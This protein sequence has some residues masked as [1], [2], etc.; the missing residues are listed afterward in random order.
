MGVSKCITPSEY[1]SLVRGDELSRD[2]PLLHEKVEEML[3]QKCQQRTN[4]FGRLQYWGERPI[5]NISIRTTTAYEKLPGV[6]SASGWHQ[7]KVGDE[8]GGNGEFGWFRLEFSVP[9]EY[10]GKTLTAL[11]NLGGEGCLFVNGEPYQGVDRFHSEVILAEKATAGD[12][13]EL[14]AECVSSQVWQNQRHKV[15]V[16][17]ASIAVLIPAV[18][19]YF[20]D[21]RFLLDVASSLPWGSRRRSTIIRAVNKSVDAFNHSA[22]TFEALTDSALKAREIIAPLFDNP[23]VASSIE[24]A[25]VGHSHIDTAWLWPYAET[26]RKCARTFSTVDKLMDEYEFYLFSQS[27]AQLYEFTAEN[28]PSLYERLKKRVREGRFEPIGSMW[29]EADCNL[30][31]GEALVRQI[32]LGKTYFLEEFGIET[33]ELWLPDVFGYSAAIPQILRKA[34]IEYFKTVKVNWSQFNAFPYTSFWW[35]GIDGSRVLAHVPP[36]GNYNGNMEAGQLRSHEENNRQKDRSDI[37]LYTYGHGDGGGGPD[38]NHLEVLKRAGNF[39]GVPKCTPMKVSRFFEELKKRSEDLPTWVG[40]LYLE[41]HRGTYTSQARNKRANRKSELLLRDAEISC[42]LAWMLS[43]KEYPHDKLRRAWKLL[44]K[45]QF[46]DVIPGTSVT[47]VY[48]D[49]AR[50]YEEIRAIGEEALS[51]GLA[52]IGAPAGVGE[53]II[54]FNTLSFERSDAVRVTL[55]DTESDWRV[56]TSDGTICASQRDRD[57]SSALWFLPGVVPGLGIK[58]FKLVRGVSKPVPNDIAVSETRLENS[59]CRVEL[60]D[61][62]L[63]TSV[64]DKRVG[65]EV[66]PL[67]TKANLMQIFED[68]PLAWDAWDIEFYY[69]DKG[70]DVTQVDEVTIEES[71]PVRGSI[72][73]RRRMG[74]SVITQ[75]IVLW[76]HSPRIDFETTVDWHEDSK[77]LKVAFPVNVRTDMAT[78]EIQF[79]HVKRPTHENTSWEFARFEV[80]AHKWVDLSERGYGVSLLNDCKYGHDI[81]NNVMRLTLLRS[82]K[83][84][85]PYAD[86]GQHVFTY[87]LLPHL[88]NLGE[89]TINAAYELNVPLIAWLSAA[90][91]VCQGGLIAIDSR[92]VIIEAL[93]K[94]EK[95]DALIV[96]MYESLGDTTTVYFKAD[97]LREFYAT[98]C[99]LLERDISEVKT[100]KGL[101]QLDFRPFEIK[102]LKLKP[103]R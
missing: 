81:R 14:I 60:D 90:E 50:D 70:E 86:M 28:Y 4:H 59:V 88:N 67:G 47:D 51:N 65:K 46:H 7:I 75:R 84:P 26:I 30:S 76:A 43:E 79:G 66:I 15:K 64:F 53:N 57:N 87:S 9:A 56:E 31:S 82:P 25:C 97:V 98:E 37:M 16:E 18:R 23:A 3:L 5:T 44:C 71:G 100:N 12:K 17:Q 11:L 24:L 55:P 95:E 10:S 92:G 54:V 41:Y 13:Y 72:K 61:H 77:M 35:Q 32:L 27:Q 85:D 69:R 74:S 34:G 80:P 39:E 8:W 6:L 99:D 73:V 2:N 48:V 63:I 101:I 19:D 78:Y 102:T 1:N 21:L 58:T 20:F 38:K 22:Q 68:K 42:A 52:V 103:A 40:E 96:R 33:K 29:V 49:T 94:A 83:M 91:P 89:I 45:N 36:T 62:L 93:K